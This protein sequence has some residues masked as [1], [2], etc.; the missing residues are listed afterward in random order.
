MQVFRG[1]REKM[2]SMEVFIEIVNESIIVS[3]IFEIGQLNRL[4]VQ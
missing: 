2:D 1:V 4:N 3:S